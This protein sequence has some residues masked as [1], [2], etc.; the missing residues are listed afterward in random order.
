MEF[1]FTQLLTLT[2]SYYVGF[3]ALLIA[4]AIDVVS[5]VTKHWIT[6]D[7][8]SSKMTLK[9][10]CSAWLFV[11]V[12]IMLEWIFNIPSI[13]L[14]II[15]YIVMELASI[16]ENLGKCGLPMPSSIIDKLE[17]LQ[18]GDKKDE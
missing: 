6:G 5:G 13:Q 1:N 7:V 12:A 15:Y 14:V 9:R 10:K 8:N 3:L 17:Q 16:V 18:E 11:I 2:E 4:Q